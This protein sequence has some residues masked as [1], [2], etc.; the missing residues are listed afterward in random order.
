MT[1]LAQDAKLPT[2]M[3]RHPTP[4]QDTTLTTAPA[5]ACGGGKRRNLVH[6]ACMLAAGATK[7][8]FTPLQSLLGGAVLGLATAGK[9]R[10]TGRVLGVSGAVK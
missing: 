4:T 6:V 2:P 8:H 5:D 3:P 1:R 10:S 7:V 9:L